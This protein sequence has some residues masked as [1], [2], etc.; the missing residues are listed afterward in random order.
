MSYFVL[1]VSDRACLLGLIRPLCPTIQSSR[2]ILFIYFVFS[3]IRFIPPFG[4]IGLADTR[5]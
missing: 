4:D 3:I 2:L 5:I 1:N